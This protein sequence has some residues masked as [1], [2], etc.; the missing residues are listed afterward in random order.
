MDI[1]KK[2]S[3]EFS[4]GH[5]IN[6]RIAENANNRLVEAQKKGAEFL[7][8]GPG[9]NIDTG[10]L[11]PSIVTN[12]TKDM[13]IFE[14]ETFGPSASLYVFQD[15]A[16]AIKIANNSIYGLNAAVHTTNMGRGLDVARKLE[17]GQVHINNLTAFDEGKAVLGPKHWHQLTT[18]RNYSR[19]R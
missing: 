6:L 2:K 5:A 19:W 8:G 17:V 18:H 13:T 9:F 16:D 14:E 11:K 4:A 1:M 15:D 7:I 3:T 10:G 12:V